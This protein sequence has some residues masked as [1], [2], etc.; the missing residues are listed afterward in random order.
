M[1]RGFVVVTGAASGIGKASAERLADRGYDVIPAMRRD[2]PLPAPVLA[3]VIVD[4]ADPDTVHPA[5]SEILDR[6]DGRLAGLVNNAGINVSGPFEAVPLED[7]RRQF[8][9]NLFGH[10]GITQ[11][12]LP[13]L[14][15]ARGRIINVGSIGG[16]MSLPFLAPYSAS[17]FAMHAWT[18]ALRLELRPHGVKVSLVEPGAIATPLWDKGNAAA[19][20][21]IDA[22]SDE[23][24]LRYGRQMNGALKAAAMSEGHA[25]PAARCAKVIVQAVT[26]SRPRGR[27]LVGPDARLQAAIAVA[28]TAV[29]D[30]VVTAIMR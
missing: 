4:L 18:D 15:A 26:A 6:C 23:H 16:R 10:L 14:L 25:I 9:V 28:P 19:T 20:A 5:C 7:W 1:S 2:E 24:R 21:R 12:L 8:E 3:P 17:K 22:L 30:R 13:A 27:Y 11:A 29:F